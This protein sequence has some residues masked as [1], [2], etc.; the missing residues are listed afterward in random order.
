MRTAVLCFAENTQDILFVGWHV[1]SRRSPFQAPAAGAP[2][3]R[4]FGKHHM[5][6]LFADKPFWPL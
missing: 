2:E 6:A 1:K 5:A 3:A 4:V